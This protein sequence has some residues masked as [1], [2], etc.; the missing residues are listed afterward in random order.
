MQSA[1]GG[2]EGPNSR[3]IPLVTEVLSQRRCACGDTVDTVSTLRLPRMTSTV[4]RE[5]GPNRMYTLFVQSSQPR[6]VLFVSVGFSPD[7]GREEETQNGSHE[8][9]QSPGRSCLPPNDEILLDHIPWGPAAGSARQCFLLCAH[10]LLLQPR[11]SSAGPWGALSEAV[12]QAFCAA[13]SQ[14]RSSKPA[15]GTAQT[16]RPQAVTHS[17]WRATCRS[18]SQSPCFYLMHMHLPFEKQC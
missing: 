17:A 16:H 1:D 4:K 7:S 10:H 18:L 13:A 12:A 6:G 3:G 8:P 15:V 11:R 5:R 9:G 2:R 14:G